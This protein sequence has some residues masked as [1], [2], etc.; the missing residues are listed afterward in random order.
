MPVSV[1]FNQINTNSISKNSSVNNGQNNQPDWT[2]QAKFNYG[3]GM[4]VGV[5]NVIGN[6]NFNID[7]DGIDFPVA[8][9]EI[10][11]PQPNIQF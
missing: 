7:A 8:D 9:P 1:I 6:A 5:N 4:T 11:N 2:F 10:F 3:V